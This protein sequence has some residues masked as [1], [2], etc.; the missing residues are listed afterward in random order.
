MAAAN[1]PSALK[2]VLAHEGGYVDHPRDPGGATNR[3]VTQSTYDAYR[4]RIGRPRRPV[5]QI[6]DTEVR[7]LYRRQYWARIRGDEL[8]AG[9]DYVVFDAAVHSG[10]VQAVKWLQRALGM[11]RVDG[12]LGEATLAALAA[13]SDHDRLI[14]NMIEQRLQFMRALRTYRTFGRGWRRRVDY[15]QRVGQALASGGEP[16]RTASI[17]GARAMRDRDAV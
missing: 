3:G 14:G 7:D 9:I 12:I 10:P 1:F 17:I 11:V 16:P 5:R 2:R 8:P 15:V 4:R 13:H 6:T